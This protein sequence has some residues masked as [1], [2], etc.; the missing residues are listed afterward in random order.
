M[1][2][3]V[4][5]KKYASLNAEQ[6]LA[7]DTI[8][9]PVMV[10]AGPGTGKTLVLTMRIANIVR[11]GA[12]LPDEIVALTFT[13]SAAAEMRRRVV[14]LVGSS[15]YHVAIN[16]FHG[17]CNGILQ[18]YPE[19]FSRFA[20]A[21]NATRVEQIKIIREILDA[22]AFE[23]IK[24][25]SDPF[26][27]AEKILGALSELKRE[28]FA[29]DEYA[30]YLGEKQTAILALP[31]LY[32]QK[33]AHAGKMQGKYQKE[34]DQI[35]R[36]KELAQVCARYEE[37]MEKVKRYDF[38]D[39]IL[40]VVRALRK[41]ESLAA[42][43]R[44]Q[45]GY[46]LV[47]EH[48]DTNGAQNALLELLV[49]EVEAPNLF[50]VGDEKQAIFRFQGASVANFLYFQKKYPSAA[51]ITLGDNYR[52][53]Q[54][55][56][57][58]AH[59]LMAGGSARALTRA[60]K[61]TA[62]NGSG[63]KIRVGSCDKEEDEI[64]F[65]AGDIA[66]RIADGTAPREIAVIVRENRQLGTIAEA[67]EK[68]GVAFSVE[69]DRN[70]LSDIDVQKLLALFETVVRVGDDAALAHALHADF[71][72]V[73]PLDVYALFS[74]TDASRSSALRAMCDAGGAPEGTFIDPHRLE[75]LY[76]QLVAWKR[77]ADN[78]D[79]LHAFEK[80]V[81]ESGFLAHALGAPR[82][83]Q[84]LE[85]LTRLFDEART[86]AGTNGEYRLA[87]FVE[88]VNLLRQYGV[89][90]QA[91]LVPHETGVRL[92]TAHKAKGLEF[93]AVYIPHVID[94][95]W[96]NKRAHRLFVIPQKAAIDVAP[97]ESIEDERR[98][99]FVAITRAKAV[100][101]ITR[102]RWALDGKEKTPSQFLDEI[103]QE[104]A[105]LFV[106]PTGEGASADRIGA[107]FAPRTAAGPRVQDVALIKKLF[108]E[109]G[110]S[111]TALNNYL[112]CPWK[113]FY[114]NLLRVPG[115]QTGAQIYGTAIHYALKMFFDAR[116]RG[117]NPEIP[118]LEEHFVRALD[119][120]LLTEADRQQLAQRG[121]QALAG[122]YRQWHNSWTG[123]ALTEQKV[124]AVLEDDSVRITGKID[125]ME[126]E[127]GS[128][129]VT[130]IDYK[131][132]KPKSRNEMEGKTATGTGDYQRQ[133]VFYKLLLEEDARLGVTTDE[134]VIDF[135]EPTESGKYRREAFTIGEAD[136]KA[137]RQEIA[138]VAEEIR[139]ASFW[140]KRC[141]E[142]KCEY[143]ALRDMMERAHH[144]GT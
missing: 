48:Q 144:E 76:R 96:G 73:E 106:V 134:G 47:D 89:T 20:G 22:E 19:Y 18:D 16:T 132:G 109:R 67:L 49:G 100:C 72:K 2:W 105:E 131:T 126:F 63:F 4:F 44:D 86:A 12:A 140:E 65:I 35:A 113:Y 128:R 13:E 42:Q 127:K 5:D 84:V 123:E 40:S 46:V 23:H 97:E 50:V 34:L 69:S 24:P 36:H 93:M 52:S 104:T 108:N 111:P 55:V 28:G 59:G 133:L 107:L 78:H 117:E 119:R 122:Y 141:D 64:Q 118:F 79:V 102:A 32:H 115:A 88:H 136:V 31:D 21:Q 125:K 26:Q 1:S 25:A 124:A 142:L 94:G 51:A 75:E 91:R 74:R 56:L 58:A 83:A 138:R 57:D 143:C 38:D 98:L 7:V 80:I 99:L 120:E 112:A 101:V 60:G 87:D 43:V 14:D 8:Q 27:H 130:V 29:S 10:V 92:M 116:M 15:G 17:L 70:V 137:L 121:A 37:K 6:K 41:N 30:H 85:K 110:L 61:L 62:R 114:N 81:R 3:D 68:K 11:Q 103:P 66:L 53:T 9:G 71:L 95:V 135:I 54:E 139:S 33:G 39:M 45:F 129:K 82:S 77:A 90:L